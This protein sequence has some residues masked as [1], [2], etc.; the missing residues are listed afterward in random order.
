MI[1]AN[2][3]C[4]NIQNRL[5][6]TPT[7]WFWNNLLHLPNAQCIFSSS[8]IPCLHIHL[9]TTLLSPLLTMAMVT[10]SLLHNTDFASFA[11]TKIELS[12]K[13]SPHHDL[14]VLIL[15]TVEWQERGAVH[16]HIAIS[17]LAHA[18]Y[19]HPLWN[20]CD[21]STFIANIISAYHLQKN[22]VFT[23]SPSLK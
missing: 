13:N 6:W 19:Q 18:T 4:T 5:Q 1:L 10:Q 20:A 7:D 12:C 16:V 11:T 2:A 15:H 14:H 21:A 3:L 9:L 17:Q 23:I 8:L 22:F